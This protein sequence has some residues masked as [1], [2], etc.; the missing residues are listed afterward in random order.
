MNKREEL[1][2]KRQELYSWNWFYQNNLE[3]LA[4]SRYLKVNR[5][6]INKETK[7]SETIRVYPNIY[8]DVNSHMGNSIFYSQRY[9]EDRIASEKC[10]KD[11]RLNQIELDK[12]YSK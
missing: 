11:I 10:M 7:E 2:K 5:N 1:Q 9:K 4:V 6:I 12:F 3:N 8:D